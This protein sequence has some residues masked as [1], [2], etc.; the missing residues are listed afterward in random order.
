MLEYPNYRMYLVLGFF[1]VLANIEEPYFMASYLGQ[2]CL[3]KC[4]YTGYQY[5]FKILVGSEKWHVMSLSLT[6]CILVTP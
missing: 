6:L 4:L 3:T 1:F 2:Q 5:N